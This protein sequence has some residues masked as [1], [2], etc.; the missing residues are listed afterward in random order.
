MKL[1][2]FYENLYDN[3]FSIKFFKLFLKIPGMEKLLQYETMSY[4][5][6]G[7]LTFLVSTASYWAANKLGSALSAPIRYDEWVLFTIANNVAFKWIYV[8]NAISWV[9]AVTFAFFTNKLFVFE[10]RS[11]AA[12]VVWKEL[13]TFVSARIISFILFEELLFAGLELLFRGFGWNAPDWIAKILIAVIVV[14]FNYVASKLVIFR[15]N[16]PADEAA[17]NEESGENA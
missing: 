17:E 16:K 12:N 15:K 7:F 10:S 1:K 2:N 9:C 14:I 8:A 3:I 4:L 13:V 11:F 6:F 5:F